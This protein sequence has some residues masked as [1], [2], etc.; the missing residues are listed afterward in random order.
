MSPPSKFSLAS[1]RDLGP[2]FILLFTAGILSDI[3]GFSTHTALVLHIYRLTGKN[4]SFMGLTALAGLVPMLVASPLGGIWAEKYDR[5][6]VMILNDLFRLPLVLLMAW[7]DQVWV[8]LALQCLISA[9][10]SAF[11]PSRQ[12][13]I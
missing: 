6:R 12:S 10:T 1:V 4:R 7:T 11:N 5:R 2:R 9:S 13:I 8:I 3:G